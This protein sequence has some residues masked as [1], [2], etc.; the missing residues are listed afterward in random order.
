MGGKEGG[1]KA[2]RVAENPQG[3]RQGVQGGVELPQGI[4]TPRVEELPRGD[5]TPRVATEGEGVP[6]EDGREQGGDITPL[7]NRATEESRASGGNEEITRGLGTAAP[8]CPRRGTA[9]DRNKVRPQKGH[10]DGADSARPKNGMH[11]RRKYGILSQKEPAGDPATEG[12]RLVRGTA[13]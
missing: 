4:D 9:A 10:S 12:P 8:L 5:E 6:G 1:R 2:Y 11:S 7:T 3:D 13:D